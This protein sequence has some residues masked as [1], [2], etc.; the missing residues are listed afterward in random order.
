[1]PTSYAWLIPAVTGSDRTRET[2]MRA[3]MRN[4]ID[5]ARRLSGTGAAL[6]A[7]QEIEDTSRTVVEL[8]RRLRVV[9][10]PTP[11]RAA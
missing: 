8:D 1:M 2:D 6:N 10:D 4:L 3:V 11:R 5:K 9:C 7:R